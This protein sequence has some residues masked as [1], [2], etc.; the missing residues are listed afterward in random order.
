MVKILSC[1]A[2]LNVGKGVGRCKR[3]H[4]HLLI[5]LQ[6]TPTNYPTKATERCEKRTRKVWREM[7][8][9]NVSFR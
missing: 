1:D 5:P 4:G 2:T 8:A 3:E 6:K 7:L 9:I